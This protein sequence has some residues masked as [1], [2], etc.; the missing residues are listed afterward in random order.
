M[1]TTVHQ[2]FRDTA[3]RYGAQPFL[4][5]LPETA[6]AYGIAAGELS[7]AQ[8]AESIEALRAAY[9]RAGYG[10]GHRAG[11]L[12]ENRPSFFLHW[13][14]LNALGVSVVP[15]NPDLR[16]AELE[17]LTGHSEI[18]LAVALPE[19][20]ADLLAAAERAGRELRVMGP[21]DTPPAAPFAAPLAGSEPDILT[22]CALLYTSGT[23]GR[24]KGCIL[25][26]R[27]FLHAGGWYARIGGLCELRPGQERMLTPLPLVHMNAMAYS[28][29]A[30]LLTGGCLIPLDR[31]HPK[32]WWDSVRDSGA[33][34]LHYLGVMP[35]IL[36]KAEPSARDKQPAIRFGFGAGV[37]RKL[38]QP[39]EERFGFPLLEAWAMTE[40]GAGAVIIA[41]HEPRHIGSSCFGREE[42]D[43][44]V[45]IV[46]DSGLE[47]AAGEPGELLVRH[48]GDDPRYGFF[49][50]YLKDQDATSQAWEDGWFHTG[51]IVRRDADGALRF[52]DRKKNVIRRSG[53]N[54]SAVEVESVLLQHP[55]VKAVA[56]AAVPDAVRGDEVLA[57]VVPESLP[58]EGVAMAEAARSIVQWSLEQLAYYK[59]PGYVAFVDS[60][61][62]TT[63]NKIQRGEM[64]ALAPT[65]PGTARCVDTGHM[66]KRQEPAR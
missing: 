35:A 13:F 27:Y 3:A 5:I 29:M 38:H 6:Q 58:A 22:E 21:D 43:V 45:R 37:D 20:H 36:M 42:E 59:A 4:C 51:D 8:A 15:I 54:I 53:E 41:N 7:Y 64:K 18:A 26:N 2:A 10:H 48:A 31:F 12:L 47:A 62:L 66:K 60:L 24:P 50:G 11:L 23:T 16:A 14:A 39:F 52:V 65:L 44:L 17:Y 1:S 56:V 49:A 46:A 25:P 28:A 61:P 34:V 32:T 63:T 33:T 57:C 40:T 55:L 9:A 19:R 30:M